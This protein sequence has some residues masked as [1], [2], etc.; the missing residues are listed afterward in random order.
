M[1][2]F[3]SDHMTQ[4]IKHVSGAIDSASETSNSGA[5][6]GA[7]NILTKLKE[8]PRDLGGEAYGWCAVIWRNRHSYADWKVLLLLSLEVGFRHIRPSGS[9]FWHPPT[10]TVAEP[11]QEVFDAVLKSNDSESI[12]D[13]AWASLT[14]DRSGQLGLN[15]LI[16]H[17][18]NLRGEATEPFPQG[19]RQTFIFCG[20]FIGSDALGHVGE[21]R[22]VESL[23][24]LR[25]GS[26]D[27]E[28]FGSG[29]K[30]SAMLLKIVQSTKG[31][32]HLA[33]QSWEF[34]AE[35]ATDRYS[36]GA[37]YNPDVTTSFLDGKEWDKL[38]CWM[39]IVW[40]VWPPEP[41]NVAKELE[42]ATEVLEKERPGSIQKR[43]ER[44]SEINRRDLPE[45][46]QQTY[47]KLTL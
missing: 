37:T 11:H 36:G 8:R 13:L 41:G 4:V 9:N 10:F 34:L 42:D 19:L 20:Q 28:D 7:L 23:N 32:Q 5:I 31:A 22:F 43:M 27:L 16:N 14:I 46:F 2:P 47:D 38:E 12:T 3:A 25:I 26:G 44:W 45:S 40:M 21:E 33:V 6:R 24:C 18:V 1:P 35:I 39:S 29:D 30:W 15:I 17:I